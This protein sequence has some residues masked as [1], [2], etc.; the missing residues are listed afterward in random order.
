[1]SEVRHAWWGE[2]RHGGMLLA[3]AMLD[4]LAGGEPTPADGRAYEHLRVAWLRRAAADDLAAGREFT[5]ALLE[6]FLGLKDGWRKGTAVAPELKAVGATGV[7]L[8]PDWALM[9]PARADTARLV[10]RFNDSARIGIGRGRRAHAELVE[11]LR[12]TGTPLGLLTNGR[13]L[14]LVHA[15]PDYDAW[16]EWDLAAWFDETEGRATLAGLRLLLGGR[17]PLETLIAAIAE[18][19]SRQ[20]ELAQVLGE[21]VRRGVELILSATDAAT[22]PERRRELLEHDPATGAVVPEDEVLSALYQAGT[23]IVMRLVLVLYAEARDL[24][25]AGNETYHGSYGAESLYRSLGEAARDGAELTDSQSAWRRL[26]SLFGLVYAGSPHPDLPVLAYGGQLFRPGDAASAAV[27]DRAMA[28]VEQAPIDDRTVRDV[29]RLLKV[30]RVR[31]R[32]GRGAAWVAGSVD[33]SDLRTEYIGIVYEGLIDYEL[34]RAPEG[35]PIVFLGVG[36]QPALPLSRLRALDAAALKKLLDAFKKDAKGASEDAPEE[37]EAEEAAE[38]EEEG[39]ELALDAEEAADDD[40][41]EARDE[42]MAWAREAVT[43][44]GLVKAPRGRTPDLTAYE[45]KVEER[46]ASLVRDVI[47]PG[48]V[49]LV[50]SGGLRKG[51]GSFYTRPALAVPLAHRTLEPLCYE[52]EGERLVPRR[53]EVILALKVCEPAMGSGSFLVAA[54]RYLAEALARS[55]HDHGLI[56]PDGDSRTVITLPFGTPAEAKEP[57]ETLPLPP[58]DDRF[59]ERLRAVLSRHIVERCLYGVDRNPM[60]VELAKLSLWVETLD[61]E[62]P[63]EFLD[64]KLKA[65]NSLVGGWLHLVEDYPIKALDREDSEGNTSDG[66]RWLKAKF[67]AAKAQ[68]PDHIRAFGGATTLLDDVRVHPAERVAALRE[69]FAALHDLPRDA[70]ESA[71]RELHESDEYREIRAALDAWCALWFWPAGDERLPLP[72]DWGALDGAARD[73]IAAVARREGFLHWELEFP[74]VFGGGREGFDAVLGNPPWET[75]QSESLEFF[76]RIDPLYRAYGKQEALRAQDALFVIEPELKADWRAYE[77]G[78]RSL[79]HFVKQVSSPFEASLPG[80]GSLTAAWAVRVAKRHS[81][82]PYMHQGSGKLYTY[83][84]FLELAYA[85]SGP[86]GRVGML[87]SGTLS[88]ALGASELRQLFLAE[89]GWEWYFGFRNSRS[90]FAAAGSGMTFAAVIL[91]KGRRTDNISVAFNRTDVSEWAGRD[92]RV[93]QMSAE[94]VR[95]LDPDVLSLIEI[96]SQRDLDVVARIYAQAETLQSYVAKRGGK[97]SQELNMTTDSSLFVEPSELGF[98]VFTH[99]DDLRDPRVQAW[100]RSNGFWLLKEGKTFWLHNPYILGRGRTVQEGFFV[101]QTDTRDR[102]PNAEWRAL[103]V[104]TR[105]VGGLTN[106]RTLIPGLTSPGPHGNSAPVINGLTSVDVKALHGVLGSLVVDYVVRLKVGTNLNW[107]ILAALPIPKPV[108]SDVLG[109][110]TYRLNAIG[111]DFP[112]PAANPLIDPEERLAAR[113]V[114]DA[115]VADLYGLERDDLAHIA[116]RFP[117]YDKHAGEHRYT[118]LVVPVYEAFLADGYEGAQ[119]KAAALACARK[120]AGVGFGLDELWVPPGGWAQANEEARQILAAAGDPVA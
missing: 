43:T 36:R 20:G 25:P 120:A 74:D 17:E 112:E 77:T 108:P 70:R 28:L 69:R 84:L 73:G 31:V 72:R 53:P 90:I 119:A 39:T 52:R 99:G 15:G 14:R 30:G 8:R 49:Y 22:G 1:M 12:A 103:R 88:S 118:E 21:Q 78:F 95:S 38:P 18:S 113:L 105:N 41:P 83:K 94:V 100:A 34:R 57:E 6:G 35:D 10:V 81:D 85:L 61:R 58:E 68:L 91:E 26:L 66:S 33:F 24:L 4:G 48:R 3:P 75:A 106:Q 110:L 19:R 101:R 117:I 114:L 11:L 71:Y 51:S 9:D 2:L 44:A 93:L 50:A 115:L 76:S 86:H 55:L 82:H 102:L 59:D 32:R 63:F 40:A 56:R 42:A 46:A 64:H 98:D 116:T 107:F 89:T 109:R 5:G 97:Y 111:A 37:E 87:V 27:T 80:G 45:R 29:L 7:A 13:Q 60:A 96:D 65:G 54:L 47:A 92:P 67:R 79:T 23:R 104:S 16:A 62:L